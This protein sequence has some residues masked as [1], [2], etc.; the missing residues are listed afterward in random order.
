M[1]LVVVSF[2]FVILIDSGR[3]SEMGGYG[4]WACGII[5]DEVLKVRDRRAA[6]GRHVKA[7]FSRAVQLLR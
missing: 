4:S 6:G 3:W 5:G 1:F 2:V 7:R